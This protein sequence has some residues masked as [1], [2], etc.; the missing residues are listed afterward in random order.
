MDTFKRRIIS[1]MTVVFVVMSA[2]LPSYIVYSGEVKDAT[3][4]DAKV[5]EVEYKH[6]SLEV[7]PDKTD[8]D[9][10]VTL[11]GMMSKKA[12]AKVKDVTEDISDPESDLFKSLISTATDATS[13]DAEMK[14][15]EEG[16]ILA[17]YDITIMNGKEEYQP[18]EKRPIS[19]Q[20]N[21]PGINSDSNLKIF[22]IKDDGTKE[23]IEDLEIEVEELWK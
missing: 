10:S 2:I 21:D 1:I 4:T 13:S 14:A 12:K 3:P 16:V 20:I 15:E 6:L 18:E 5:K 8:K 17:A 11:D 23:E 9:K 7:Y 19:V 22:H